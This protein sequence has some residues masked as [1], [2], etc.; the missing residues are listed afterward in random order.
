LSFTA[1]VVA[2]LLLADPGEVK[3]EPE[4]GPELAVDP[5]V[6]GPALASTSSAAATWA[7]WTSHLAL[8]FDPP[9]ARDAAPIE[10]PM[11]RLGSTLALGLD[12]SAGDGFELA[13]ETRLRHR[14]DIARDGAIG[15]AAAANDFAPEVRRA[16]VRW[17]V[18]SGPSL[19]LGMDVTRWGR[20]LARPFDVVSPVD[21]RDGPLPPE[22]GE[23]VPTFG[24]TLRQTLGQGELL[25]LWTP[26][27]VAAQTP[28]AR[29]TAPTQDLWHSSELALR[30]TQRLG[31]LDLGLGWM[32][33]FDRPPPLPEALSAASARPERQHV[34][35]L[36][37]AL[38]TGPLRWAAEAAL[39]LDQ[40]H[41]YAPAEAATESPSSA[42]PTLR[43]ALDV[44]IEPAIFLELTFGLEG[45]HVP[46]AEPTPSAYEG[47]DDFWL[48]ARLA[49]LLAYD[50]V[51]RLDV[52]TRIGLL[53]DDWW[54]T[55]VLALRA[56]AALDLGLGLA[57]LGG[58]GL[59]L[60]LASN[61]RRGRYGGLGALYGRADQL[62]LRATFTF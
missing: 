37:F 44:A 31:D 51:L 60:G 47:P 23:R 46:G 5:I 39:F 41:Y 33:R 10:A 12:W 32:L 4:V 19:A 22:G 42:R 24:L 58:D 16:L 14:L 30:V 45:A 35:G 26:F 8:T 57:L 3:L 59:D 43:W 55:P 28:G 40:R 54:V 21:W 27:H 2:A 50:G 25:A 20:T 36:E 17:Q 48:R 15:S 7:R 11:L 29:A 49:L 1:I 53:R 52:D 13:L 61:G 18:S 9:A 34:L 56:S 38:P 62:W 6:I